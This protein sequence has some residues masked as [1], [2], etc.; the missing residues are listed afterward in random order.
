VRR[1]IFGIFLALLSASL[2]TILLVLYVDSAKDDAVASV[3]LVKV[4]V[5][6][7]PIP[8][9]TAATA[10]NVR[11]QEI[12][13]TAKAEN[14]L[15][16]LTGIRGLVATTTLLPGE[17]LVRE[18]FATPQ[19]VSRGDVPPGL[20]E[21]TLPVGRERA[22]GGRLRPG[23]RVAVLVT[24]GPGTTPD[25]RQTPQ[26]TAVLMHKVL[27]TAVQTEAPV[28]EEK[29]QEGQPAAA[30]QA[31][32]GSFLVTFAVS[33]ADAERLVFAQEAGSL[34]LAVEPDDAPDTG[35]KHVHRGNVF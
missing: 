35:S 6:D 2:G 22:V 15:L 31:P 29:T 14:A 18:R 17:Q 34:W 27:V 5:V 7:D 1:R 11:V 3:R 26:E 4:L 16:D 20:L 30:T 8:K 24:F 19:V 13:A 23:G 10:E 32:Q 12:P 28:V 9:G 33:A 25:G 21:V